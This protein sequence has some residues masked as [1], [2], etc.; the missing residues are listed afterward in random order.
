MKNV[1]KSTFGYSVVYEILQLP[2]S[3]LS[4][5]SYK[6]CGPLITQIGAY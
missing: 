3:T 1:Q 6:I 2:Q 4:L 5:Y